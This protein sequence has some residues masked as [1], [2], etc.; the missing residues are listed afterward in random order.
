MLSKKEVFCRKNRIFAVCFYL[1]YNR[2]YNI[3]NNKKQRKI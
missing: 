2:V 3:A 1:F